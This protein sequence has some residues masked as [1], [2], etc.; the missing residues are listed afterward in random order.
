LTVSADNKKII[1]LSD[2]HLGSGSNEAEKERALIDLLKALRPEEVSTLYI[3][4][5][6][7]D[8]WFEYKSAILSRHF[9]VLSEISRVIESGIDVHLVVGNHDYWAG[10]FLTDTVG[11]KLHFDPIEIELDG[12]RVY[13]CHGDGLN[14]QD[15]GYKVLKAVVRN[16]ALIWALRLV[17]PDFITGLIRRFSKLSRESVSVAGKLREDE[18]I[19]RFAFRK[20]EEGLDVVIAGHS[21]QPQTETLEI[22]GK[23]KIYFNVGDMYQSFTCIEYADRDFRLITIAELNSNS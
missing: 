15:G 11:M 5:D 20:L 12:L 7:F 23:T 2:S 6:L 16:K 14:P 17:H 22:D 19:R 18:G 13:L 8:F 1:F 3:L 21:H 10:S 9:R 4:G